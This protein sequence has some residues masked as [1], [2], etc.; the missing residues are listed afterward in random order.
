VSKLLLVVALA[1]LV[2][3]VVRSWLAAP[4]ARRS[5]DPWTVLGVRPDAD[6]DAIAQAYRDQLKRYHPDR[7]AGLG[8]ELQALAHEKTLEIQQAYEAL[9]RS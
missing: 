6:R 9:T 7:V 8:D 2:W 3:R 4:L 5:R 1:F